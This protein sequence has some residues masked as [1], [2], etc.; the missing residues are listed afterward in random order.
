VTVADNTEA[1]YGNPNIVRQGKNVRDR[2]KAEISPEMAEMLA[3]F[4]PALG[5]ALSA[6]DFEVSRREGDIAGMGLAGLGMIP[7]VGGTVKPAARIAKTGYGA[8]KELPGIEKLFATGRDINNPSLYAHG[9]GGRTKAYREPSDRSG[10]GHKLQ[11]ASQK[12]VYV[13]D[14]ESLARAFQNPNIA[15]EI[16]PTK[17]HMQVVATEPG[18]SMWHGGEFPKGKVLAEA[19]YK[20]TPEVGY[21]PVELSYPS[22]AY[23]TPHLSPTGSKGK[24][25][26]FGS[27]ITEVVEP[28]AFSRAFRSSTP[29]YAL[30]GSV[31][32]PKEYSQ[33]NWKLI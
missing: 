18:S 11:G 23:P 16:R 4:H 28:D 22:S 29:E 7:M 1:F 14:P 27:T 19:P 13:D 6:K 15:T 12:T 25:V 10:T 30:G 26:H 20:T 31:Q 33:G 21:S 2:P 24:G 17:T 5:S 3:G 32:M 8:L 9:S